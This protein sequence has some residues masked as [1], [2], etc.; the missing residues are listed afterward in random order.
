MIREY[1]KAN[2][3]YFF[4]QRDC[5][6]LNE[7]GKIIAQLQ[8]LYSAIIDPIS[9]RKYFPPLNKL[10][11]NIGKIVLKRPNYFSKES[12]KRLRDTLFELSNEPRL[13][14]NDICYSISDYDSESELQMGPREFPEMFKFSEIIQICI[15]ITLAIEY[16]LM[17]LDANILG[18]IN[19][20]IFKY[21]TSG[22]SNRIF[23]SRNES[24]RM[25]IRY[26]DIDKRNNDFYF[27][28]RR[29]L[30]QFVMIGSC[31]GTYR[32]ILAVLGVRNLMIQRGAPKV[33]PDLFPAVIY[34]KHFGHPIVAFSMPK[35]KITPFKMTGG[36][37]RQVTWIQLQD[38]LTGQFDR[39]YD[40]ILSD[41]LGDLY[42]IDHDYCF[43]T[44]KVRPNVA[45]DIPSTM[46]DLE[47]DFVIHIYEKNHYCFPNM[48]LQSLHS[49]DCKS[50][51][52]YCIPPVID[53]E[54]QRIILSIK[55]KELRDIYQ[56]SGLTQSEIIPAI[57][58]FHILQKKVR[59]FS[60]EKV[61][62]PQSGWQQLSAY[63]KEELYKRGI[64][65]F[66][67]YFVNC[68]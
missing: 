5:E 62:D 12:I 37:L 46:R 26:G 4:K 45:G 19:L 44:E 21:L 31:T 10:I 36:S 35:L 39:H 11:K 41:N 53:H 27:F 30:S 64:T 58:R 60:S 3:V 51:R 23:L 13:V 25:V 20:R 61:I 16:V 22:R 18:N 67:S 33:I 14:I 6:S 49:V 52:N 7:T 43:P 42:A 2:D 57:K 55:E 32:R 48:L 59:D 15:E 34:G 38:C 24:Q 68:K 50:D 65:T 54:M 8:E 63:S 17:I 40:N 56:R 29:L 1:F 47:D 28:L 9:L 66:N